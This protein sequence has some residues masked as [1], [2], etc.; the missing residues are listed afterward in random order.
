MTGA[1]T[2]SSYIEFSGLMASSGQPGK[3]GPEFNVALMTE[4]TAVTTGTKKRVRQKEQCTLT[5]KIWE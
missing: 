3:P 1:S 4:V 5:R 2:S